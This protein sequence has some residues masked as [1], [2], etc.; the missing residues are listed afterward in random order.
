MAGQLAALTRWSRI[1]PR[2]LL[3]F[4]EAEYRDARFFDDEGRVW[5]LADE[6]LAHLTR[7]AMAEQE[8]QEQQMG[9]QAA[10]R[11]RPKWKEAGNAER[12]GHHEGRTG[13][14][15]NVP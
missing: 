6:V 9:R 12:V 15:R 5:C 4:T 8:Q 11:K 7:I 2:E 10:P 3:G 14:R 13:L 1:P